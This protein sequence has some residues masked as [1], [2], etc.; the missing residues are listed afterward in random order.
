ML[1]ETEDALS[2]RTRRKCNA[3]RGNRLR[4]VHLTDP[5]DAPIV[6]QGH[7][8]NPSS[9]STP[10][11][12]NVSSRG[13]QPT[14][15]GPKIAAILKGLNRNVRRP[16]RPLQ[17]RDVL[18]PPCPGVDTPGYSN[19]S[20]SGSQRTDLCYHPASASQG[21]VRCT[22]FRHEAAIAILSFPAPCYPDQSVKGHLC[23]FTWIA[24]TTVGIGLADF[25]AFA[26]VARIMPPSARAC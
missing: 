22:R 16:V 4:R 7:K 15:R 25:I 2:G 23:F 21:S 26:R 13:R 19:C 9:S 17:G 5:R 3:P 12:S 8:S 11:G 24:S 18:G 14:V 6:G 1:T 10:Q 20:P